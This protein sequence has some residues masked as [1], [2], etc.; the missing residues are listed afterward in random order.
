MHPSKSAAGGVARAL[1]AALALALVCGCAS[2]AGPAR[3][4][5]ADDFLIVD[6]LRPGRVQV[7]GQK[8]TYVSRRQPAR[9]PARQCRIEGGEYTDPGAPALGIWLPL[10][11]QG[12]ASAQTY[13][14]EIYEKG[15]GIPADY[16]AA[17]Q[18]YRKAAEQGSVPAAINLG[19][20]YAQ[21][22]GVPKDPQQALSWYARAAGQTD[23]VGIVVP[24]ADLL[25][26]IERLRRELAQK[27]EELDRTRRELDELRS[28]MERRSG[29]SESERREIDRLRRELAAAQQAA[30]PSGD[31]QVR[32]LERRIA[33]REAKLAANERELAELR[34][35]MDRLREASEVQRQRIAEL[36][37]KSAQIPPQIQL[38]A[39]QL[40]LMRG[41]SV[42]QVPSG[43]KSVVVT[44]RADSA[45]G[46]ST[47]EVNDRAVKTAGGRF[48]VEIPTRDASVRIVATDRN[49]RQAAVEFQVSTGATQKRGVGYP[50]SRGRPS[51]GSYHAL[52]IGND[53]YE[54]MPKLE[55][56]TNDARKVATVLRD[57][58][59]FETTL[60]LNATRYDILS[61]LNEL[62]ERLT[63][64]DNLVIYYA[65]HGE[66][67]RVNQRGNWLPV[68]A[69]E[70]STANWIS[71]T[72]IT[73]VLNAMNVK[74]LLVVSDS[75]YSG[76]LTRS[77]LTPVG[78]AASEEETLERMQRMASQR[79]RL[80]LTS[81]GEE[82]VIDGVG[83]ANS[84]FARS[85]VEL[86]ESNA[87]VLPG[88]E[89][90]QSLQ[91]RV[92]A[93]S[94]KRGVRQVPEYAP[95]KFA[96]HEAGDFFFVKVN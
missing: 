65:G 80:V 59:G 42:A 47:L 7:L 31:A 34:A 16:A 29:S 4:T 81:G 96:G 87:G 25:E 26:E 38:D 82:P 76:T 54:W 45:S 5:N 12:D 52:V 46:I 17:A 83:G 86:L 73:D 19:S 13:V 78:G 66:L 8:M 93:A 24:P 11:Q 56:A 67:D 49:R 88:Q 89:L 22:L 10:A 43:A 63:S 58:Y 72:A 91:L 90:F 2:P 32:E 50:L 61:A 6:C 21:G 14:G 3:T 64:K 48:R 69:E 37:S 1:A 53:V 44:G 33:D 77:A 92:T 75:C 95:I 94:E 70:N 36:E 28:R 74:Q 55:T 60:L 39:P 20:L 71:N 62:R 84:V 79:S 15:L 9:I 23:G 35:A 68:D 27:E 51:F 40:T 30:K 85:F 41:V 57:Q 18:W